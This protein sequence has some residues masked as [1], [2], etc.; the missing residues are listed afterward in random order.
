MPIAE[1]IES[2]FI[3]LEK[4]MNSDDI[5]GIQE[6]L[7]SLSKFFSALSEEQREYLLA[8]RLRVSEQLF[9]A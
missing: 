2:R 8:A 1:V 5:I 6:L 4:L 9:Q 3:Q 7:P